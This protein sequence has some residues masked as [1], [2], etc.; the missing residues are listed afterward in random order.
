[1]LSMMHPLHALHDVMSELADDALTRDA[2]VCG[3]RLGVPGLRLSCDAPVVAAHKDEYVVSI[4]APGV[5]AADLT[6]EAHDGRIAVRG[7]TKADA[8]T[9]FINYSL[10]L[11]PDADQDAAVAESADGIVTVRVPKRAP[12]APIRIAVSA[13]RSEAAPDADEARPYTLTVIAAGIAPAELELSVEEGRTLKVRGLS[14]RTGARIERNFRLPRDAHAEAASA[15]HVDGILTVTVPKKKLED[16]KRSTIAVG[17]PAEE[18]DAE[19]GM[20]V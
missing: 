19:E 20:M 13:A 7:E 5:K 10:A 15:A 9:H 11:P 4:A 1:M 3:G 18:M 8:H 12:A 16:A 2:V 6:I 14:K 17:A